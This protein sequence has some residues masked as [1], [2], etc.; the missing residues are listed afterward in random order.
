MEQVGQPFQAR[1]LEC[2]GGLNDHLPVCHLNL[3]IPGVRF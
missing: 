2:N 3:I 1:S